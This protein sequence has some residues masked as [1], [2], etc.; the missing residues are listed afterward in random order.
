MYVL[1]KRPDRFVTLFR[2]KRMQALVI[3]GLQHPRHLNIAHHVA[4]CRE[5]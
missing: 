1:L 5:S 4:L 3:R 2:D